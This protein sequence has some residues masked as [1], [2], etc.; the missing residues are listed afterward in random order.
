MDRRAF[1]KA[2]SATGLAG[3]VCPIGLCMNSSPAH[4]WFVIVMQAAAAAASLVA[5]FTKRG[6]GGLGAYLESI[7]ELQMET[8]KQLA[9]IRGDILQLH[10]EIRKLPQIIEGL[11]D[12]NSTNHLEAQLGAAFDEFRECVALRSSKRTLNQSEKLQLIDKQKTLRNRIVEFASN[13]EKLR[14]NLWHTALRDVSW[15]RLAN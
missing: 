3:L 14:R 1:L 10:S 2:G 8:L 6:D 9:A 12:Q 5:Q 11:L 15:L 4:A 13:F 7:R